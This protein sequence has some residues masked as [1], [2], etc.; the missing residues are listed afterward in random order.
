MR[1]W[2]KPFVA[3]RGVTSQRPKA[4]D[5]VLWGWFGM[6]NPAIQSQNIQIA[7]RLI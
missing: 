6:G 1:P 5:L 3:A 2:R 4:E 7:G